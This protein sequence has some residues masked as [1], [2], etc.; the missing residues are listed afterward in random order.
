[1]LT[2]FVFVG[3]VL[4]LLLGS[5]LNAL[6]YRLPRKESLMTR[7]HCTVCH[8]QITAW[9]NIPLISW[10]FLRGKCSG[11]KTP[12]SPRYPII[13]AGTALIF[14][15]FTYIALTRFEAAPIFAALALLSFAFVG[16][17]LALIDL[18]TRK[19]P[20]KVIAWGALPVVTGI[21][22][23]IVAT[24]EWSRLWTALIFAGVYLVLYG[25]LWIVKPGGL[26]FGDV[27]LSPLIG[28]T[29]GFISLGTAAVGFFAAWFLALIWLIPGMLKGKVT[30]KSKIPFGPWMILGAFVSIVVGDILFSGYLQLGGL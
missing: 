26:G 16:I 18:D 24:G 22:G 6:A 29:L 9:E 1:V 7:S 19:L 4:G 17:L 5:F 8:K 14:G 21:V 20:T 3:S 13:E 27:R 15:V 25:I 11:C 30:G 12:I 2:Y 28:L 10:L 23:Y